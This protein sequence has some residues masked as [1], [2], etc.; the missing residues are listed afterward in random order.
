M[1]K[2]IPSTAGQA[3]ADQATANQDIPNQDTAHR[4]TA[5]QNSVSRIVIASAADQDI[6]S[7][8]NQ[9]TLDRTT[10]SMDIY[11]DTQHQDTLCYEG[12]ANKARH[13]NAEHCIFSSVCVS[14]DPSLYT[15]TF[16]TLCVTDHEQDLALCHCHSPFVMLVRQ[17]LHPEGFMAIT[18]GLHE[19][20]LSNVGHQLWDSVYSM[21]ECSCLVWAR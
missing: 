1:H 3:T 9:D 17:L 6:P 20:S 12:Q 10:C 21:A 13:H 5:D 16:Q 15:P 18:D 8:V 11:Q 4:D 7:T 2:G 19:K 14:K